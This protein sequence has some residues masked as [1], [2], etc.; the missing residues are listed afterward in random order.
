[1]KDYPNKIIIKDGYAVMLLYNKEGRVI[2]RTLISIESIESVSKYRWCLDQCHN[3]V[4][5]NTVGRLHR[6]IMNCPKGVCVDHINGNTLDNRLENLR[7]CNHQQNMYNRKT[8]KTNTSGHVGVSLNRVGNWRA[9]IKVEGR[10]MCKTF[11]NIGD[12]IA[13]R[14]YMEKKHHKEFRRK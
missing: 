12:A 3:Y 4:V 2:Q 8:P 10:E 7:L 5:N 9:R 14:E 13:W 1:M 11:K 6:Y